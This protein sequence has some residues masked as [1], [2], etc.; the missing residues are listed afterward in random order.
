[1]HDSEM[2]E[3]DVLFQAMACP[4]GWAVAKVRQANAL[5]E[6]VSKGEA[7]FANQEFGQ[8]T[9]SWMLRN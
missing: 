9:Y 5:L 1:M 4:K 2:D 3:Q 7:L 6:Y 8:M